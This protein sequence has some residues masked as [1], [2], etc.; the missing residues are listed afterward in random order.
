MTLAVTLARRG[1]VDA[2]LVVS[3]T[4]LLVNRTVLSRRPCC[5]S[6]SCRS[7]ETVNPNKRSTADSLTLFDQF[8]KEQTYVR[9][10]RK[11]EG[12]LCVTETTHPERE[13]PRHRAGPRL[14]KT[15]CIVPAPAN[16]LTVRSGDGLR[17]AR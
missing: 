13:I 6:E 12:G 9:R 4:G 1:G 8:S 7:C 14:L 2:D 10:K 11:K 5:L 16:Y 17:L 3:Y 15:V